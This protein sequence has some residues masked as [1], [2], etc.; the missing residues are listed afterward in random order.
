LAFG[1]H[2]GTVTGDH[3]N[4]RRTRTP[5]ATRNTSQVTITPVTAPDDGSPAGGDGGTTG[6]PRRVRVHDMGALRFRCNQSRTA[7]AVVDGTNV[8]TVI[9]VDPT[10]S[11]RRIASEAFRVVES[12]VVSDTDAEVQLALAN[13]YTGDV[14]YRSGD[15]LVV[16]RFDGLVVP[17]GGV[18][19]VA[20]DGRLTVAGVDGLSRTGFDLEDLLDVVAAHQR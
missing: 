7:V 13:P 6:S 2:A 3:P 17:A 19:A 15:Q 14:A 1:L 10:W 12:T 5:M 9:T 8:L 4:R 16:H 11:D 18:D 20:V